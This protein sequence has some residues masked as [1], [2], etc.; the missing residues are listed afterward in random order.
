MAEDEA[1]DTARVAVSPRRSLWLR[2]LVLPLLLIFGLAFLAFWIQR[3]DIADNVIASQLESKGVPATYEVE[4]I[5]GTRQVLRNIV[6]GDPARPDLTVERAEVT[7]RYR[8]GLPAISRVRLV[9]PR[10]FGSY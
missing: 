7:I 1:T 4:R 6:I 9:R 2:W 8:F 10:L 3:K 5:G